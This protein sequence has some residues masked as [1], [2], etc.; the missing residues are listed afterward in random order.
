M[1]LLPIGLLTTLFVTQ[2]EKDVTFAAKELGGNGY[3]AALRQELAAVIDMAEGAGTASGVERALAAVQAQDAAKAADMNA[4]E[5]AS[6]AAAAVRAAM[7]LPAGTNADAFD[8]ALDAIANHIAKVEDGSNLTLDPDLDSYYTQDL[9]TVKLPAL[10]VAAHHTVD[11]GLEMLGTAQPG[12]DMIVHFL[13]HRGDLATAIAG[14]ASDIEAGERGNPDGSMK[15]SLANSYATFA[16][17][18]A[19][20]T[21]MLD[22]I[23]AQGAE[24]PSAAALQQSHKALQR[25]AR[26]LLEVSGTELDH[27]LSARIDRLNR[28]LYGSMALTLL[29]LLGSAAFAW[30]IATSIGRPLLGLDHAMRSLADGDIGVDIPHVERG[31]EVGTM[32][33][34]VQVF[35][36]N[37]IEMENLRHEQELNAQAAAAERERL[38]RQMAD[39]FEA[40]VLGVAQSVASSAVQMHA[41]AETMSAAA[42]EASTQATTVSAASHQATGSVQT[43]AAAAEELSAS[44]SEI[45]RQVDQAAKV[46]QVASEETV[47]T[48]EMVQSLAQAADRIGQVVNLIN[49]IASQTNLLA[50]NATIEAARAG[51]AGKGFAVVANEVKHLAS[52]TAR[53]TEEITGQIASVQEE[54]RRAVDAIRNIGKVIEEVGGISA[55]IASA[56]QQQGAATLEIARN[57]S[58]AVVGT[59]EVSSS[60]T[61]VTHAA[62]TTGAAA[63]EVLASARGLSSN[64]NLLEGAVKTFL[65]QVRAG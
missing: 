41:T 55:E 2:T 32:A 62:T 36:N 44:I 42:Q 31:D 21:R 65:E 22:A 15:A 25:S 16:E 38:M 9:T 53:A 29:V 46:S 34:A 27:L 58:Q 28:T 13:T 12:P 1:F 60:I 35:K 49:D 30:A 3:F 8:P 48:N 47:R 51:D 57:V 10:L 11:A 6:K 54:T 61:G 50:L 37:A 7:A 59:T 24:R 40:S 52:Q 14:L 19:T 43:V 63:E 4:A 33:K 23:A 26:V 18:S 20:Y 64:S 5:A 45:A 56:V 39:Q 17:T